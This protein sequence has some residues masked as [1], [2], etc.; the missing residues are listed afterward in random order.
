MGI[1]QLLNKTCECNL[2]YNQP[3]LTMIAHDLNALRHL[4]IH[5]TNETLLSGLTFRVLVKGCPCYVPKVLVFHQK[6]SS[7]EAV[8]H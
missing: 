1:Q 6:Q 7:E 5:F 8:I 2:R 3:M 4:R